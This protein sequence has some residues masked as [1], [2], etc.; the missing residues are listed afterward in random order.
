MSVYRAD[1]LFNFR[2]ES[3]FCHPIRENICNHQYKTGK[4]G[5][6][7]ALIKI[8]YKS[9]SFNAFDRSAIFPQTNFFRTKFA[10]RIKILYKSISSMCSI[11]LPFFLDTFLCYEVYTEDKDI[12]RIYF[13]RVFDRSVI[14]LR[15]ISLVES[16]QGRIIR[17]IK[18]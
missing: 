1:T 18:E 6:R 9:T 5:F 2:Y 13:V 14:F 12:V 7:S 4:K 16:L 10:Q 17:P 15:Q 8:L 11:D 3:N